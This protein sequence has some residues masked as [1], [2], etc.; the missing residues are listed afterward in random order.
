M[1]VAGY[2][3]PDEDL[4]GSVSTSGTRETREAEI[5]CAHSDRPALQ[6]T[7]SIPNHR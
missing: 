1:L 3:M 7:Q 5:L 6:R 2:W 4:A